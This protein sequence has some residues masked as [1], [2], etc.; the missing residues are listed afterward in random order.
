MNPGS[1]ILTLEFDREQVLVT[2]KDFGYPFEPY[3]PA[4]PD[5]EASLEDGLVHGFGL[6]LIYQTMDQIGYEKA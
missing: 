4:A 6:Y 1:I 5:V 3:E 2:L